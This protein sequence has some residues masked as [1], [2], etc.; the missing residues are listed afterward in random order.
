MTPFRAILP[1]F[2]ASLCM[3]AIVDPSTKFEG[4]FSAG[5]ALSIKVVAPPK[6]VKVELFQ[7]DKT[8]A[9][10]TR[11][12]DPVADNSIPY[13]L[14]NPLARGRYILKVTP[15]DG[16]TETIPGVLR[17][18]GPAVR[19][20]SLH[21]NTAYRTANG[22]GFD[23]DIVGDNFA[24]DPSEDRVKVDGQGD[25]IKLS[26]KD[27]KCEGI[28]DPNKLPCLWVESAQKMHVV[29]YQAEKYQGQLNLSVEVDDSTSEK[30]QLVLARMS[31]GGVLIS[32]V[33][34]FG[35]MC[36]FIYRLVARNL[37][38]RAADGTT[39]PRWAAFLLDQQTGTYSLSKF[40]LFLF[41]AVFVFGYIYLFL[42][43]WLVQWQFALPDVPGEVSTMLGLSAG[44]TVAAVGATLSRGTKGS[45]RPGPAFA[46]FVS[47]GGLVVAERFQFF[48]WTI[49]ACAGFL[50]L[51]ISQNPATV[52]GFPTFPQGLL[53]VMGISSAG[54]LGGKLARKPGPNILSIAVSPATVVPLGPP[55]PLVITIQGENFSDSAKFFIDGHELPLVTDDEG[56]PKGL[57]TR[58]PQEGLPGFS[59]QLQITIDS[60]AGVDLKSDDHTFRILNSDG[61]FSDK[62]FALPMK[63]DNVTDGV[64]NKDCTIRASKDLITV[65]VTG[66]NCKQGTTA[67]W[68]SGG[69]DP[70]PV[71]VEYVDPANLKIKVVPGDAGTGTL[72]LVSPAGF[73]AMKDVTVEGASA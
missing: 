18:K 48:V 59:S 15:P 26:D 25:I 64:A 46:D 19:L 54:Y 13:T 71:A 34:L 33:V 6:Q 55:K 51:V 1:F 56:K 41:S 12:L 49:V 30:K 57:V 10:D 72:L 31:A 53:Y 36:F 37:D 70:K 24:T 61:Q 65:T 40:Q 9:T 14:P 23:F 47:N 4:N 44:T 69:Q 16:A 43:H 28:I 38:P 29:G 3:A 42:C 66:S 20:D 21:P 67:T 73:T 22:K 32:A 8:T 17:V 27:K 11:T 62:K 35:L 45:G 68:K 50:A 5:Q 63:I 7:V 2:A 52:Q 58:T 39:L 60:N